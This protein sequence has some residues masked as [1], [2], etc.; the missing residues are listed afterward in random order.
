MIGPVKNGRE[1][2]LSI[3]LSANLDKLQKG[4]GEANRKIDGLNNNFQRESTRTA[5]KVDNVFSQSM[6]SVG[7]AIAAAFSVQA[8]LNFGKEAVMLAAKAEGVEAAFERLNQ[9]ALLSNLRKATRGTITDVELMR[10][11]VRAENFKVP[12]DQL[13]T[14]FEFA[15][16]RAAQTGESVDYLV[17]SIIDG[18]GRKSTLVMDNLGISA[19]QLQEEI[20]KTGDFGQAA[21]NII[22]EELAKAG[23]VAETTA[24]KFQKLWASYVN[25]Q[26]EVGKKIGI[27]G[28][29]L[30]NLSRYLDV[31]ARSVKVGEL[32]TSEGMRAYDEQFE[33]STR[34]IKRKSD[35]LIEKYGGVNEAQAAIVEQSAVY[36]AE[37]MEALKTDE[38]RGNKLLAMS[39][40]Y[41]KYANEITKS[42]DKTKENT[43]AANLNAEA[44]EA[45][46]KALDEMLG[47]REQANI[48]EGSAMGV[49]RIDGTGATS[50]DIPKEAQ[51]MADAY[52]NQMDAIE[53]LDEASANFFASRQMEM[54]GLTNAANLFGNAFGNAF[55][56]VMTGAESMRDAFKN[57]M[58]D[59]MRSISMAIA[60]M[61]VFKALSFAFGGVGGAVVSLLPSIGGAGGSSLNNLANPVT[62]GLAGGGFVFGK[63]AGAQIDTRIQGDQFFQMGQISSQ[64][65]NRW[66]YGGN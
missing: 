12:L 32:L 52:L 25:F 28:S 57:A 36:R 44:L 16:K 15:T 50:L 65:S 30:D 4:L 64:K 47:L 20:K 45:Q 13:A 27:E 24:Q 66:R 39:D 38:I 6:A 31:L 49:G 23:D 48:A 63:M 3:I 5:G 33:Q 51:E 1:Y 7:G 41:L 53:N 37:A 14:F 60:R 26:T 35:E 55:A 17:N 62:S 40:A 29:L 18:I 61:L 8:V 2:E 11:A 22:Q 46:K 9:P 34:Q 21:G 58:T 43:D 42:T 19:A 56:D 54:Q 10:Q 59:I